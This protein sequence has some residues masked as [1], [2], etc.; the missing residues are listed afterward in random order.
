MPIQA[1]WLSFA[2]LLVVVSFA[3][4]VDQRRWKLVAAGVALGICHL[5]RAN[6]VILVPVGVAAVGILSSD[7]E[8]RDRC[9]A[10][11]GC[12]SF[13]PVGRWSLRSRA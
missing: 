4:P 6:D 9:G 5:V 10:L 8:T 7:V 11:R 2:M 3:G 12:L 1:G 13:S